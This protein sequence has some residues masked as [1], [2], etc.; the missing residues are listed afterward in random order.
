MNSKISISFAMLFFGIMLTPLITNQA[1]NANTENRFKSD[2]IVLGGSLTTPTD[3]A[4][5][6]G[7]DD[8]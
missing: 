3:D 5:F 7:E 6:G 4:S 1:A 8:V 2:T